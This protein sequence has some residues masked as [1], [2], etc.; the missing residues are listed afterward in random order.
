M[1]MIVI[2]MIIA[3]YTNDDDCHR[4]VTI[5]DAIFFG[6][7]RTDGPTNE[8]GDSRSRISLRWMRFCNSVGKE[9]GDKLWECRSC[10]KAGVALLWLPPLSKLF[11]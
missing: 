4:D 2:V 8:Q 3:S 1:M 9:V 10:C 5:Y 6:N 11:V 7:E